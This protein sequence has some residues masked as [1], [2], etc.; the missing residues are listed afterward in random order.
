MTQYVANG[1]AAG[2]Q[3][4]ILALGFGLIYRTGKVL[5]F[6]HAA[7]FLVGAYGVVLARQFM[8]NSPFLITVGV[9]VL[10]SCIFGLLVELL[11]Y[12]PLRARGS[13][14]IQIFIASLG[15]YVFVQNMISWIAGDDPIAYFPGTMTKTMHIVNAAVTVPQIVGLAVFLITLAV[16]FSFVSATRLGIFSKAVASDHDIARAVGLPVGKV[17]ITAMCAGATMAGLAG[18]IVAWDTILIPS[19][20]IHPLM[21]SVVAVFIGGKSF[22]GPAYGA[23]AVGVILHLSVL[24]VP[25]RWQ[26]MT[27]LIVLVAFLLVR[28]LGSFNTQVEGPTI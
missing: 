23:V 27:T 9:G 13:S 5:H 2:A 4:G 7:S 16:V 24:V 6:A 20:A 12:R 8:S 11:I 25:T 19:M 26:E 28:S 15:I 10:L 1:L 22:L 18:I 3:I 17:H 14:G 21:L